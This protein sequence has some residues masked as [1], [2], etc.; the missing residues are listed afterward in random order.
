MRLRALATALLGLLFLAGVAGAAQVSED[1]FEDRM[2]EARSVLLDGLRDHSS[3]LRGQKLFLERKGVLE[4]I[5]ALDPEDHEAMRAL[6]WK[7]SRGGEWA[8]PKKPKHLRNYS[9]SALTKAGERYLAAIEP[10]LL[11]L[12]DL[13]AD[14]GLSDPQRERV[15]QE[16]LRVVPDDP[17]LRAR[18]GEVRAGTRWVLEET[19]RAA[20]Q[21]KKI[22]EL[23]SHALAT[24]DRPEPVEAGPREASLGTWTRVLATPAGLVFGS[25]EGEE[26][27]EMG[28]LL[29]A[30]LDIFQK[31]LD[32]RAALPQPLTVALLASPAEAADYLER[33]PGLSDEDRARLV[34]TAGTWIENDND[35]AYWT[36]RQD[37]RL[38]GVCRLLQ[39]HLLGSSFHLGIHRPWVHEGF[40]LYLT[41]RLVGTRQTWFLPVRDRDGG[42]KLR[43]ALLESPEWKRIALELLDRSE[44]PQLPALFLAK[45]E[46]FAS[47]DLVLSY[48]F[49]AFLIEAHGDVVGGVLS[50]IG[51][52]RRDR[53]VIEA[54]LGRDLGQIEERFHRWLRE[55]DEAE[56]GEL[57][58]PDSPGGVG[59]Q[60]SADERR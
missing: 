29:Q 13:H 6:G 9:E 1:T 34:E 47:E 31:L 18:R 55:G 52:G 57:Q 25:V 19:M 48:A 16:I 33:H 42:E 60:A 38:D 36:D 50:D 23:V 28:M 30:S 26:L 24:L 3:W 20:Y 27:D 40:G 12:R 7:K 49:A 4:T 15:E 21:R 22:E 2:A 39:S 56:R 59:A 5:I 10:A 54:C 35:I 43:T 17:D 8:P 46:G 58:L 41:E 44:T 11:M 53:A 32:P 14:P 45:P 37:A 51:A